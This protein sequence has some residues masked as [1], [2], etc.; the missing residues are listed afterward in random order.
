[1]FYFR[2]QARFLMALLR[3]ISP[4]GMLYSE[5]FYKNKDLKV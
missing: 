5:E 4:Q 2:F 1:M 3:L